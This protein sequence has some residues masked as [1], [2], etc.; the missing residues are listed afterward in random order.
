LKSERDTIRFAMTAQQ[1]GT[2]DSPPDRMTRYQRVTLEARRLSVPARKGVDPVQDISLY[3]SSGE[4]VTIAGSAGSGITTLLLAL[5]GN[6][7]AAEGKVLINGINLY[8]YRKNFI[9]QIGYVPHQNAVQRDFTVFEV[10]DRS[11]QLRLPRAMNKRQRHERVVEVIQWME[12][13]NRQ[14]ERVSALDASMRWRVRI[15]SEIISNPS[16]VFIDE[17][18]EIV[19]PGGELEIIELLRRFTSQ[20]MTVVV[21][22]RSAKGMILS[23]KVILMAHGGYLAWFGPPDEALAYFSSF[24]A[25]P[26]DPAESFGFEDTAALLENSKTGTP[27]DWSERYKAQLAYKTYIDGPLNEKHPDLLLEDHPF[28]R[29][30]GKTSEPQPPAVARQ[31][32]AV[33]QFFILLK[34]NFK[35][36]ARDRTALGLALILPLILAGAE[37]LLISPQMYDPVVGDAA[38]VAFITALLAF[39]AMLVPALSFMR[40]VIKEN[41]VYRRERQSNLKTLPY[42]FSKVGMVIPIILYQALIWTVVFF[43]ATRVP[44]GLS[45]IPGFYITLVLTALVGSLIGL[46][47]SALATSV[48]AGVGWVLLLILPQLIFS[49]GIIPLKR[50]SPVGQAL[51][52]GMPAR[53]TF[54]ALVTVS[55]YGTDLARDLCWALPENQRQSLTDQQK[56]PCPCTG[57]NILSQCNFPGVRRFFIAANQPPLVEPIPDTGLDTIPVQPI[58]RP[59]ETLNQYVTDVNNYT[60][61][62]EAYQGGVSNYMNSLRQYMLASSLRQQQ[63]SH[64]VGGAEALIAAQADGYGPIFNVNLISRWLTLLGISLVLMILFT[65]IQ[66]KKRI[67]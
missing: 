10:L 65:V 11:A 18:D 62:L 58:P 24:R 46:L 54:E 5:S 2:D 21:G 25:Q 8:S 50:L 45:A 61:Q 52:V 7:P 15:A 35:L 27:L 67:A 1:S 47:A 4:L 56:Q 43:L 29:L 30:R 20:G 16:L 9:P 49:G 38:Q 28:S 66:M 64:A 44:G 19:D 59:G 36:L 57:I 12:L 33:R 37:F 32:S 31:V 6:R 40:E 63:T 48:Q 39:L 55:G 22:T 42:V 13:Q 17:P 34:H 53:Y 51:T 23:D 60:L 14:E 3:I 26:S 41:G